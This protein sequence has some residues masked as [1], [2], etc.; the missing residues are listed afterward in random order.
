MIDLTFSLTSPSIIMEAPKKKRKLWDES[1]MVSAMEA[2]SSNSM[3]VAEAARHFSVPRKSLENR[4][5]QRVTHGKKS[6]PPRVLSDEEE[7]GLVEYIKYMSRGGFPMTSKIICAYAWAISKRNGRSSRFSATGPSW[8]WWCDFRRRHP[9]LTL[10]STDKLDRG[11]ARNANMLVLK[12]YFDLLDKTL[13]ENNMKNKCHRI[14]NCDESGFELDNTPHKVLAIKGAKHVYSQ[15]MGTLEHITVHACSCANGTM[16]PPM[17]IFAK[18]FPGGAYTRGGPTNALYAKSE[19]GYMDG[20]LYLLW[21][22]KIFLKYCSSERPVLLVQDGHKSHMTVDLIDLAR[23]NDVILFNLPPHT[24]H[25]TQPLDKSIFKPLKSAFAN[26]LKSVTFARQNFTLSKSDFPRMFTEPYDKTCTPFRV[27][28]SFCDAGICPFDPSKIK[29]DVLSPSE[30]FQV[31]STPSSGSAANESPSASGVTL[32]PDTPTPSPVVSGSSLTTP[33]STGSSHCSS[34]ANTPCN[35]LLA[36]G[37][38]P[39]SL[40]DIF[41]VPERS[42]KE[43]RRRINTKARVI[44]GDEYVEEIRKKE[45]EA[46]QKEREKQRRKK[47][48]EEKK[49]AKEME[50]RQKE[51]KKSKTPRGRAQVNP[52]KNVTPGQSSSTSKSAEDNP[53]PSGTHLRLSRSRNPSARFIEG[54][55]Q[56]SI[57]SESEEDDSCFKCGNKYPPHYDALPYDDNI[58]WISCRSCDRWY[59]V[60]CIDYDDE[61]DLFVCHLCED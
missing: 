3:K 15:S 35:P 1:S 25:A 29:I 48:R 60:C 7:C 8:H 37:L 47:E 45:E 21:F 44:T 38:I 32:A 61:L 36:A 23:A 59:H 30:H 9:E 5:K 57:S 2:V 12:E 43:T 6:G 27:K 49:A 55:L 4:V 40:A 33:P 20:E 52:R 34:S 18:G 24:T 22:K 14:Y 46:Q 28:Q 19:S 11:R 17:I 51:A 31:V 16:L 41:E 42:V 13:V 10:R 58:D 50:K 53:Q 54:M 56:S 26:V 39:E